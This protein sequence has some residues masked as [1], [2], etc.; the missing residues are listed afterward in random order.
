M[1]VYSIVSGSVRRLSRTTGR[2]HWPSP[3]SPR[4]LPTTSVGA[5]VFWIVTDAVARAVSAF[6]GEHR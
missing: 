1:Y 5:L 4:A 6:G 2:E 3:A